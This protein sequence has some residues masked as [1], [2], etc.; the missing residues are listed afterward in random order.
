MCSLPNIK[1]EGGEKAALTV[2]PPEAK[3]IDC[4]GWWAITWKREEKVDF[5]MHFVLSGDKCEK[6]AQT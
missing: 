1:E 6:W 3:E 5:I 4:M 2:S